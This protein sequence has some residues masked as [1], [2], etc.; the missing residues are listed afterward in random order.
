LLLPTTAPNGVP[1]NALDVDLLVI[2]WVAVAAIGVGG[3]LGGGAA[4]YADER[5]RE[6]RSRRATAIF[7]WLRRR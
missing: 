2:T 6:G 1:F 5:E 4:L 7:G 3:M